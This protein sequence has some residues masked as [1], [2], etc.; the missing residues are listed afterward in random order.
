MVFVTG[1]SRGFGKAVAL[2][3]GAQFADGVT[4]V[5]IGR[6]QQTLE[7]AANAVRK[8]GAKGAL[9]HAPMPG[10]RGGAA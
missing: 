7:D 5:L 2:S 10:G 1:G 8:T 9:K 3:L 4:V 6:A